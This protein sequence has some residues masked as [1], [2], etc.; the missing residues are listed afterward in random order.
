MEHAKTENQRLREQVA[1]NLDNDGVQQLRMLEQRVYQLRGER[2]RLSYELERL[3]GIE[4]DNR[5]G[6]LRLK[7]LSDAERSFEVICVGYQARIDELNGHYQKLI[8]DRPDPTRPLFRRCVAV[9][10]DPVYAQPAVLAAEEP[11]LATLATD[12]QSAMFK[13]KRL[14]YRRNDLC[15][16]LGG[17]AM[18]RL[19]LL[20]GMSGIGKTSLPRALGEVLGWECEVIE[21]QA[22]WRDSTD[23]FG[24]HNTFERRFEE[25]PFLQAL[26]RAQTVRHRD[27]P[28]LIVL[29]EMNLSRPEQYFSVVLSK[30]ENDDG[31]PIQ[32][33]TDPGA[34][35]PRLL[36]NGTSIT[37][38]DNVWF[39]GTANQDESTVE[40]ADK[41][42]SRAHVLELPSRRPWV[43]S[44]A[45]DVPPFGLHAM[46]A[47]FDHAGRRHRGELKKA[48]D[49]LAALADPLEQH[50]RA[51]VGPR[52]DAQ[53]TDFVPVV[54][55]AKAGAEPDE[56]RQYDDAGQDGTALA[57]DHFLATKVFRPLRGRYGVLVDDLR[58]LEEAVEEQWATHHL[59]GKPARIRRLLDDV[60]RQQGA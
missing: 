48:Q 35:P 53:L 41:T 29:D 3:R 43:A 8:Q 52:L 28:F 60:L 30:L 44:G 23:L 19:H 59:A 1:A 15:L 36:P 32:L 57:I 20:E 49:F 46:R 10:D 58:R 18:S 45:A 7:Q 38:P 31:E 39:L 40:F 21:V 25:S 33:V 6:N 13:Q 16:L 14:A 37:F 54:V 11:D 22:G 26:Y 34:R 47:A 4:Q 2:E 50:A 42:Y 24:H 51:F 27:Q 17:L 9:D 55:A 12:L 56:Q 5:L